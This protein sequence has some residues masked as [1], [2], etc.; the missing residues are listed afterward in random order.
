MTIRLVD[1][2]WSKELAEALYADASELRIICPFIKVGALESLLSHRPGNVQVITRFNLDDCAAG[3]SDIAALRKLLQIGAG[4]R[5]V[6]NLHAKLY[7]FGESRAVITSANLTEAALN[8]NHEFG[9]VAEDAETIKG[10][11]AYFDNLWQRAGNDL[12]P[13][14]VD[15][16]EEAVSAARGGLHD[17]SVSLGD[18]GADAGVVEQEA[19]QRPTVAPGVAPQAFVKFLGESNNRVP[20]SFSTIKEIELAGCHSAVCYPARR[21]PRGVKDDAI[22]FTA[23]LTSDPNDMRIFGRAIGR[24]YTDGSDDAT[25]ADIERRPWKAK[26]SRYIRVRNPE[27]VA[28]TMDNGVSLNELMDTHRAN[29]FA[30]TQR[31]AVRGVG[32]TNP[33][34]A[35]S[36]QAAVELSTESL[37]WLS[38]RLQASFNAYGKIPQDTLDRLD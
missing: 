1:G 32:N 13:A 30:S 38:E 24:A 10:C 2:G 15:A 22:I 17:E 9:V 18:F 27:F 21:R 19:V 25:P 34:K 37:A 8:L 4:V 14:Q 31:N 11:R 33:R 20:L 3:V 26:W 35:C 5:G 7:L 28:G 12:Q 29:A 6:R 36:S 16:W 23:R